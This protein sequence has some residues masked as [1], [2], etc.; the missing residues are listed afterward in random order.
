MKSNYFVTSFQPLKGLPLSPT[1]LTSAHLCYSKKNV[2]LQGRIWQ[3]RL[4]S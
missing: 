3:R 4:V 2:S 1:G